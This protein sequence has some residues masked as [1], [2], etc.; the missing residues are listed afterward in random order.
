MSNKFNN[1]DEMIANPLTYTNPATYHALF[2]H[3]RE[4]EPV[5]WTEPKG[6]RPFWLVT[7]HAE[8]TAVETQTTTFLNA[9][10]AVMRPVAIEEEFA[11]KQ[12]GHKELIRSMNNMDGTEHRQVRGITSRQFL[13]PS[14]RKMTDHI[15]GI[16]KEFVQRLVD[17]APE[18]DFV[19]SV[20]LWYPLRVIML[21]LG[22]PA[23]DEKLM[24]ELTRRIFEEKTDDEQID[25][26]ETESGRAADGFFN[27]FRPILEECRKNPQPDIISAIANAKVDDKPLGEFEQL[28]YCLTLATA[29]HDT[30]SA[31]L[32]GGLLALIEN[33]VEMKKLRENPELLDSAVEEMLRWVAP[34]KHFFR[35]ATEDTVIAGK[36]IS[37]GDSIM[38]PY[39]SGGFDAE[40]YGDPEVF[41]VDRTRNPHLALGTGPHACLGQHL[42]RLEIKRFF[43]AFFGRIDNVTL[44]GEPES[45]PSCFISGLTKMPVRFS[46]K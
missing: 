20:A 22:V 29:G 19:E 44:N 37:A 1:I 39:P 42:A 3:L 8:I 25:V 36:R 34:V 2:A 26:A 7:R 30:T 46:V 14:V 40:A 15:D 18:T 9:P 31:T 23:K 35:T 21:L 27:Y 33:P 45:L 5:R 16:A 11:A 17:L 24:L 6:V 13:L 28:S 38:I 12:G 43:V 32:A 10:R 4:N 41:R